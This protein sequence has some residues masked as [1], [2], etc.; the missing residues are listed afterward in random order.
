MMFIK[1]VNKHH[2]IQLITFSPEEVTSFRKCL[3]Y[4]SEIIGVNVS[5]EER[6]ERFSKIDDDQ[7]KKINVEVKQNGRV[8]ISVLALTFPD[9]SR[10]IIV[11]Q[12]NL[13]SLLRQVQFSLLESPK[14][15]ERYCFGI[16]E[17]FQR[18][19]PCIFNSIITGNET[20]IS[21]DTPKRK[22]PLCECRHFKFPCNQQTSS[23][24][25]LEEN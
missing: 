17:E 13:E 1:N 15:T 20:W 22:Q 6:L 4:N 12:S 14:E 11:V 5:L 8:T 23:H 19:W 10:A 2:L 18:K 9:A 7:L 3:R 24:H 16:F 25:H 21:Y